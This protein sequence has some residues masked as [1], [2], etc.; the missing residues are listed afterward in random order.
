MNLHSPS[1]V[2]HEINS[3]QILGSILICLYF[4]TGH[5]H[6]CTLQRM[7]PI[8]LLILGSV[9]SDCVEVCMGMAKTGIPWDSHGNGSKISHG[10]GMGIK[11]MG[12]GVKTWELE[13]NAAYCN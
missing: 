7:Q 11:C 6:M 8:S 1:K 3:I 12:M 2:K 4:T 10:M 13:N 9:F 5:F